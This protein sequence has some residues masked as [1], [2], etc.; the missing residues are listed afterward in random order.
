MIGRC[1]VKRWRAVTGGY[2]RCKTIG[3]QQY[4]K[5]LTKEACDGWKRVSEGCRLVPRL[6][7]CV[8]YLGEIGFTKCIL[9]NRP[10][11]MIS[12]VDY[13]VASLLPDLEYSIVALSLFLSL[14]PK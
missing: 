3:S 8:N 13:Q 10:I 6:Q 14:V 1:I 7:P 2:S 9:L 11:S 12:K 5:F 4:I